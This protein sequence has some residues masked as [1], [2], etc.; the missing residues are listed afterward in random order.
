MSDE[1]VWGNVLL[2]P[3]EW[4]NAAEGACPFHGLMLVGGV[5]PTSGMR[6]LRVTPYAMETEFQGR[7]GHWLAPG[8][9][10]PGPGDLQ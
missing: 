8:N 1:P 5:C 9:P 3:Q 4:A 6:V 2:S 10:K 7:R